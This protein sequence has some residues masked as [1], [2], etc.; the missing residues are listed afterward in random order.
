[1]LG[2]KVRSSAREANDPLLLGHYAV[3]NN[4]D[5]AGE[6]GP[7]KRTC[8][9]RVSPW[10]QSLAQRGEKSNSSKPCSLGLDPHSCTE[11][12]E[13]RKRKMSEKEL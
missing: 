6:T 9:V 7:W 3:L 10:V 1:M 2:T 13:K 8:L 11:K 4:N 12:N 5:E